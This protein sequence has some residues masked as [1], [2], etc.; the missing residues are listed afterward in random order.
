M[1][2]G[3]LY[4]VSDKAIHDALVQHK[5]TKAHVKDIFLERGIIVSSDTPREDMALYFSLLNHDYYDHQKIAE[6]FSVAR[7][8]EKTSVTTVQGIMSRENIDDQLIRLC[9]AISSKGDVAKVVNHKGLTEVVLIYQDVNFNRTDF[10]QVENRESIIS[11]EFGENGFVMRWPDHPYVKDIKNRVLSLAEEVC[12]DGFEFHEINLSSVSDSN[13]VSS[14]FQRIMKE[15][16]GFNFSDL[17]DVYL[18][19]PRSQDEEEVHIDKGSLKGKGVLVSKELSDLKERGFFICRV[20]WQAKKTGARGDLYQFEAKF[21]NP[22]LKSDFSYAV[23]GFYKE[24][25]LG[26]YAKTRVPCSSSEERILGRILEHA[27]NKV[28]ESILTTGA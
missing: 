3:A 17:I 19:N 28:A 4:F 7:R 5:F 16:D 8:K 1:K 27:A 25:S 14:F 22:E 15:M 2:S 21:S 10:K 18:F 20:I 13:D 24:K 9:E 26:V 6:A 23:H 12:E 11:V